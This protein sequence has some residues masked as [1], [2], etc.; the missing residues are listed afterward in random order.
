MAQL[1]REHIHPIGDVFLWIAVPI[2]LLPPIP[3]KWRWIWLRT[4]VITL[5]IWITL[6]NFRIAYEVPWNEIVS[7][8]ENPNS[9]YDGVGGNAALLVFAWMLPCFHSSNASSHFVSLGGS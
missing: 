7:D 6:I 2:A 9:D 8:L 4:I 1:A 3:T 5:A